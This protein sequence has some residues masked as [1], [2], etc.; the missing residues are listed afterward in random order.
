MNVTR[1][2][3]PNEARAATLARTFRETFI[4]P[5]KDNPSPISIAEGTC[6]LI[7]RARRSISRM[8]V[9]VPRHANLSPIFSDRDVEELPVSTEAL[10]P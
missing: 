10:A 2:H 8:R 7:V 4:K 1:S 5:K 9:I 3:E 6:Q